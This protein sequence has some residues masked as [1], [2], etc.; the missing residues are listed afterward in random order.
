M[1]PHAVQLM[2]HPRTHA[3]SSAEVKKGTEYV[4]VV[5]KIK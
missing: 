4:L 2:H 3:A 5:W 1:L